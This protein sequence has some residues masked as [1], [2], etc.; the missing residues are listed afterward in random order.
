MKKAVMT[1]ILILVLGIVVC[2]VS[3]A[4]MG[5]TFGDFAAPKY[6]TVT[7]ECSGD[8]TK[9]V[10]Q[11]KT[12]NVS[13]R[14]IQE[15]Y[16]DTRTPRVTCWENDWMKHTVTVEKETLT[17]RTVD[18]R[19]W[20]EH[21]GFNVSGTPEI[22]LYIPNVP[23]ALDIETDTGDVEIKGPSLGSDIRI[24]T[25]TGDVSV[26]DA[27]GVNVSVQTSTGD[28]RWVYRE[29]PPS[30]KKVNIVENL[31]LI[32]STGHIRVENAGCGGD[33]FLQVSTGK[34]Q[35]EN[36]RFANLESTG[37]TGD[38]TLKDTVIAGSLSIRRS[39]GDVKLEN[40][41][42]AEIHIQTET[43]D[44]TGSLL[45]PKIFFTETG[46]G[47]VQVPKSVSGGECGISTST[48][49][50]KLEIKE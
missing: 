22:V 23:Y 17:I 42:A 2:G 49:N 47:K 1:G 9:I 34:T 28:I 36:C 20:Y 6:E 27:V 32:T 13:I 12:E 40:S 38:I 18:T 14:S 15:A 50:I 43:G 33:L 11:G 4:L 46:T 3:F 29:A 35:L 44:V 31:S 10:I 25:D 19:K 21:I 48:G 16:P 39:T 24:R 7:T 41:D 8:F 37:S 26:Q 30:P 45:S 5:F